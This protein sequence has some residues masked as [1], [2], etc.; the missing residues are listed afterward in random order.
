MLFLTKAIVYFDHLYNFESL[1]TDIIIDST[2][3]RRS[4]EPARDTEIKQTVN[5]NILE[6]TRIAIIFWTEMMDPVLFAHSQAAESLQHS[7]F[8][9]FV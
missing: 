4:F 9:C 2:I 7:F 6:K 8:S 1:R 3:Y 5:E